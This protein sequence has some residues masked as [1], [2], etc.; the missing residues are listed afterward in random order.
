MQFISGQFSDFAVQI[1]SQHHC[2]RTFSS[3]KE[4][5]QLVI[6]VIF[7]RVVATVCGRVCVNDK[8]APLAATRLRSVERAGEPDCPHLAVDGDPLNQG[9]FISGDQRNPHIGL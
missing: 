3:T 1:F 4:C 7:H 5:I 9:G 8:Q 6:K 2:I